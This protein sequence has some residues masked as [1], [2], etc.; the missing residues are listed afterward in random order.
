MVEKIVI[1]TLCGILFVL[2][3]YP[4]INLMSPNRKPFNSE[5]SATG[6]LDGIAAALAVFV[7]CPVAVTIALTVP[8]AEEFRA[9]NVQIDKQEYRPDEDK[10]DYTPRTHR[11]T[12]DRDHRH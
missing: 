9:S 12:R 11:R 1:L 6:Y 2:C 8:S 3:C 10:L 7:G 5:N 4:I